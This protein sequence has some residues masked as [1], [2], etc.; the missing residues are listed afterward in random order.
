ML[1]TLS[2]QEFGEAANDEDPL[3]DR[4]VVQFVIENQK[5]SA[6][7]LQRRFKLGYNRAARID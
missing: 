7:L 1:A 6:S 4:I 2:G 5:A 3:Y